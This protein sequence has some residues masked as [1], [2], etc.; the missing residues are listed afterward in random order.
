MA[1][2]LGSDRLKIVETIKQNKKTKLKSFLVK[3]L[4]EP[5]IY[6]KELDFDRGVRLLNLV[7]GERNFF[8]VNVNLIVSGSN[9][10]VKVLTFPNGEDLKEKE[11]K[12]LILWQIEDLLSSPLA[13][14]VIDY[15]ILSLEDEKIKV[16]VAITYKKMLLDQI[17]LL[18]KL[19]LKVKEVTAAPLI[20]KNILST[21]LK[22]E[23]LAIIDIGAKETELSILRKGKFDFRRV[24]YF[25][26]D[27]FTT[28]IKQK[29][30][31]TTREAER[32]KQ[33]ANFKFENVANN[34]NKFIK[35]IRFSIHYWEQEET[36]IDRILLTGGGSKLKALDEI[37][38]QKLG[39]KVELLTGLSQFEFSEQEFS[40]HYL[41]EKLPYLSLGLAAGIRRDKIN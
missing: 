25:G 29:L 34:L 41:K 33:N 31:V 6:N 5:L 14:L 36:T 15:E 11:L 28:E 23:N 16:L 18:D 3:K 21:E 12:Q 8:N 19:G 1:L 26:G 35:K 37:M 24:F 38:S 27:K 7:L 2:D 22:Q 13:E 32:L 30:K 4:K 10:I 9:L 40:L 20:L 17:D 39:I